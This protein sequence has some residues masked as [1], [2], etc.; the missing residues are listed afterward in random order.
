[1]IF[2]INLLIIIVIGPEAGLAG[3]GASLSQFIINRFC[4]NWNKN[5]QKLL[6][7][8]GVA[9]AMNSLFVT[10]VLAALFIFELSSHPPR[11]YLEFLL[12]LG[13]A[14]FSTYYVFYP[15]NII[16]GSES[17]YNNY[18]NIQIYFIPW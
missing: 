1:M 13:F 14:A 8:A 5:D 3:F 15:L 18:E 12:V 11:K 4:Q 6:V 7:L 16:T 9:C 17:E 10:P 2:I